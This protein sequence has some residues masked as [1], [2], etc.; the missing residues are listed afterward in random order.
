M[1]YYLIL[2]LEG[3][4]VPTEE[5]IL[6]LFINAYLCCCILNISKSSQDDKSIE[7]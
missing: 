4:N 6:N 5:T 2:K 7:Q 3:L 1:G